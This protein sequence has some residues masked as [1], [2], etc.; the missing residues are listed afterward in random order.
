ME[1]TYHLLNSCF[2][3]K[4]VW[5]ELDLVTGCK[6]VWNVNMSGKPQKM[7]ANKELK[8]YRSLPLVASWGIWL[9]CNAGIFQDKYVPSFQCDSQ[10]TVV[11][12]SVKV[13][14]K[15]VKQKILEHSLIQRIR[16]HINQCSFLLVMRNDIGSSNAN[17]FMQWQIF[18]P[19]RI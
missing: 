13:P 18:F 9:V 6:G 7:D 1:T 3:A 4:V 2:Y 8:A 11:F 19:K 12:S 14:I 10:I 5:V 15:G 17:V 16:E